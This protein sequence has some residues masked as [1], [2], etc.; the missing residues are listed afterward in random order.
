MKISKKIY[1][2]LIALVLA[3][4]SCKE[5]DINVDNINNEHNRSLQFTGPIGNAF[6]TAQDIIDEYGD[7]NFIIDEDGLIIRTFKKDVY[8][9]WDN[10]VTLNNIAANNSIPVVAESISK[11][12]SQKIKMNPTPDVRYDEIKLES[13]QLSLNITVPP[14]VTTGSI[15]IT[16]PEL[17]KA[18][19]PLTY[20]FNIIPSKKVY[21]VN[22]PLIGDDI[23]YSHGLDSSYITLQTVFA[24]IVSTGIGNISASINISDL[25][26]ET[27]TGYFGQQVTQVKD[28][29]L[30][31]TIYED[32]DF[33]NRVTFGDIQLYVQGINP[34]GIPVKV[35]VSN[36]R[37]SEKDVP[38]TLWYL[39]KDDNITHFVDS[40]DSKA[41]VFGN[42]IVPD[43]VSTYI[44][45][46]NSNIEIIGNEYPNYIQCDFIGTLNPDNV[47]PSTPNFIGKNKE[48]KAKLVVNFPFWFSAKAYTRIDTIDFDYNDIIKEKD[49]ESIES[50]DLYLTFK[51]TMPFNI[52][53]SLS[54]VDANNVLIHKLL[55]DDQLIIE[56]GVPDS[57]GKISTEKVTQITV[58]IT[59][60][61]LKKFS[62]M[63]AKKMILYSASDTYDSA[64]NALVKLFN[65][66][67]ISATVSIKVVSKIP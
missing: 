42:P 32:Y 34:L 19:V 3:A 40:L 5:S 52:K 43:S 26:A 7:N 62:T 31:Y 64:N 41:A 53:G 37:V 56:S 2:C 61:E 38:N 20:L 44:N 67:S 13:G 58:S 10:L 66:N 55:A 29:S 1:P 51:S 23:I 35:K 27:A 60:Q 33:K 16:I 45:R 11:T 50:V 12:L 48:L 24:D 22:D 18:G 15:R 4:S 14:A 59:Q 36:I 39:T 8:L 21:I 30:M 54:V 17:K 25:K 65:S 6:F 49:S 46:G 47:N 63:N 28:A 9:K 57:Q